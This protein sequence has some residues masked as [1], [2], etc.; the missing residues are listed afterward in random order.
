MCM[1]VCMHIRSCMYVR[2]YVC[3][4]VCVCVCRY[5]C[6]YY[7]EP[8]PAFAAAEVHKICGCTKI[9]IDLQQAGRAGVKRALK[10]CWGA[11]ETVASSEVLLLVR[12][13]ETVAI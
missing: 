2:M 11:S 13:A 12:A 6:N 7:D 5:I 10:Q 9:M 3:R 1:Y 8:H 4:Y